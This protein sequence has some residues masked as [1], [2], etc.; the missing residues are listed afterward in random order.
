MS[1]PSKAQIIQ[2]VRIRPRKRV[3]NALEVNS[4]CM[5][6]TKYM[7]PEE[8][9][10]QAVTQVNVFGPVI[11]IVAEADATHLC[12][13][14]HCFSR[15]WQERN[16][17]VGVLIDGMV[18]DGLFVNLGDLHSSTLKNRTQ[19][20][21]TSRKG[22]EL[23]NDCAEVGLGGST[24]SEIRTRAWGSAQQLHN[25]LNIRSLNPPRLFK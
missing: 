7:K 17:S 5:E 20:A 2:S 13:K 19:Y 18:Q 1:A 12:G 3:A 10:Y 8:S 16:S 25:N 4:A 21:G 9:M 22:S 14:Q 15:Q 23:A 24:R 6:A 11:I